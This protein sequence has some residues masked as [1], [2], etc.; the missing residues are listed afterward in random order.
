MTDLRWFVLPV[1]LNHAGSG[2]GEQIVGYPLSEASTPTQALALL[3][4]LSSVLS[5][6]ML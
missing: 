6:G 3:V 2:F 5:F 1:R 4:L